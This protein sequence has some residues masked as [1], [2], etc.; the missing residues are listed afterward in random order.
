MPYWAYILKSDS[1]GEYYVGQTRD[2]ERRVLYHNRGLSPF[3]RGRGPWRLVYTERF[4]TRSEAIRRE[5]AIKSWK[6][7]RTIEELIA[8]AAQIAE[9]GAGG[10]VGTP[11][12]TP[13]I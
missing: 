7:R 6:S 11:G 12:T 1:S 5:R 9:C 8:G 13:G 10:A 4:A 2:P 3:T